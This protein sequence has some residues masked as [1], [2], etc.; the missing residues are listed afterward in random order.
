MQTFMRFVGGVLCL[1]VLAGCAAEVISSS[2]RTVV[3]TARDNMV[4]ESQALADKECAKHGRY[5]RLIERPHRY[6]DQFV[7]D[8]VN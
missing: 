5:A 6:S 3:V 2:P 4:A 7:F 1:F 8:C